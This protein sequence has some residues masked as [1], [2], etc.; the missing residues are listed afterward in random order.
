MI[1]VLLM[2]SSNQ[3]IVSEILWLILNFLGYAGNEEKLTCL[4]DDRY[5]VISAVLCQLSAETN[6]VDNM[7]LALSIVEKLLRFL[8]DLLQQRSTVDV[9]GILALI[10]QE[11]SKAHYTQIDEGHKY[12]SELQELLSTFQEIQRIGH[13]SN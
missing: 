1:S 7:S 10:A 12:Y 9:S 3:N 5:G 8:S 6:H 11:F 2:W 4:Q 13:D